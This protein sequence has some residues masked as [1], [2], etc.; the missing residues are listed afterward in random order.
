LD[1]NT[2]SFILTGD[3]YLSLF[4]ING[5]HLNTFF[6]RETGEHTGSPVPESASALLIT[7]VIMVTIML[8]RTCVFALLCVRPAVCSP[9][10]VSAR[11]LPS[12]VCDN[13]N[14]I[15]AECNIL[16]KS[17]FLY[18]FAPSFKI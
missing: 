13:L 15:R 4:I 1:E 18:T 17:V 12:K 3:C 6:A 9:C 7:V 14:C 16:I 10:C 2:G 11:I 5:C 8:G